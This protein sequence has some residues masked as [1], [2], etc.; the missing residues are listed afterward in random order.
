MTEILPDLKIILISANQE[1][2]I[3]KDNLQPKELFPSPYGNWFI[4][5]FE[6]EAVIF[7]HGGWGKISAAASTQYVID[8]WQPSVLINLGTCGGFAGKIE[9]GQIIL[10]EETLVYDLVEQMTE[11]Q[12]TIAYYHTL[13]D[14]SWL[15]PPFPQSII[16]AKMVSGDRDLI[17][18]EL[19]NLI[20]EHKAIAGDWESASIAWVVFHNR[21]R[22][23]ILRG[24]SDVV[25]VTGSEAYGNVDAFAQGAKSVMLSL[26]ENLEDWLNL[27]G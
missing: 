5:Q 8:R 15:H 17:P 1:W 18:Q 4:H 11:M 14:L 27:C 3:V 22:C 12:E 7:F 26:L 19:P 6:K 21:T 2:T 20:S 23:L 9:K 16:R 25:Y 13:L 24:V 10:V